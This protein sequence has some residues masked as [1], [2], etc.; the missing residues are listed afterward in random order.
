MPF[1][2]RWCVSNIF[3]CHPY[4]R[5]WSNLTSIFFT[6]VVQPP[7]SF[8]LQHLN[9]HLTFT[10]IHHSL[11][12]LRFSEAA[13]HLLWLGTLYWPQFG[14]VVRGNS[15]LQTY[16]KGPETPQKT[17][18]KHVKTSK[19]TIFMLYLILGG[20]S[21]CGLLIEI[22][23]SY[24]PNSWTIFSRR[25]RRSW[26]IILRSRSSVVSWFTAFRWLLNYDTL[27]ALPLQNAWF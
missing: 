10:F 25:R 13:K 17:Q 26:V 20:F 5:K 11:V 9:V 27:A 21:W 6:W 16:K 7:T 12:S 24:Q 8:Y 3:H 14:T 23:R 4:L 2:S 19:V 22:S 15:L 1:F 18:K